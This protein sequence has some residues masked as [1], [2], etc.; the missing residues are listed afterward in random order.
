MK[1]VKLTLILCLL[2]SLTACFEDT[3]IDNEIE[4]GKNIV[5]W[6]VENINPSARADG[7]EKTKK[8]D[9]R[10]Q[11]PQMKGFNETITVNFKVDP[12]S[13]A[14]EGKHYRLDQSS[15][16]IGPEDNYL[17]S[18]SF[19]MLTDGITPPLEKNPVLILNMESVIGSSKVIPTGKQLNIELLYLCYGDLSGTYL[20]TNSSCLDASDAYYVEITP[21]PDGSWHL[22]SAD[23]GFLNNC[24]ANS[25]LINAGDINEVC[26]KIL[27][28]N[29][30]RFGPIYNIGNISE[31]TWD[32][33]KG[34][35]T[36][37]HSQTFTGNWDGNWTSTYTRQ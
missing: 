15:V 25:G 10:V 34:I 35:L 36:M 29:K 5:T 30:L 13:T 4:N 20:V 18:V 8:F 37:T 31:G 16:E 33:A 23:G 3:T 2:A 24:T 7:E 26:G 21:N 14:I 28:T 11:G 1:F 6:R 19:T 12:N 9:L 32:Q 22:T 17:A 27:P